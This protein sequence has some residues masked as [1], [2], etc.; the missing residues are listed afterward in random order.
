MTERDSLLERRAALCLTTLVV[1]FI[2]GLVILDV[3]VSIQLPIGNETTK[4][5]ILPAPTLPNPDPGP[6]APHPNP[7]PMPG[8]DSRDGCVLMPGGLRVCD[9]LAGD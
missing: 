4:S 7:A 2:A 1:S 9:S 5:P 8:P 6:P 3:L